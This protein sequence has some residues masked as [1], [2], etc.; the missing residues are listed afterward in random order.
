M[1][2][3]NGFNTKSNRVINLAV[4]QASALG[5]SYIGSEHL[6]LGLVSEDNGPSFGLLAQRGVTLAPVSD[7]V[8]AHAGRGMKTVLTPEDITQ[9]GRQILENALDESRMRA[10]REVTPEHIL[11]ALLKKTQSGGAMMLRELGVDA[12]AL[13]AQL[14]GF[15]DIETERSRRQQRSSARSV[16]MNLLPKYAKDLCELAAE[17]RLDPVIGRD[18]EI[19]RVIQ[20]LCRRSKN[21]PCLIGEAGVGKTAVVEGLAQRIHEGNVPD[22]IRDKRVMVLDL[23]LVVAGTKYRGDFEDRLKGIISEVMNAEHIILFIDEIHN[24]MGIGAAEGAVDAANI[25]KPQ[26]ARGE[27]QIIGA[28]TFDEYRKH[29]EKDAALSRRFQSV[30]V[31]EPCE[32]DAIAIL[33]GLRSRYE[34]HHGVLISDEAVEA[35]V[36]LSARHISDRFLPDKAVDL[37]DEAAAYIKIGATHTTS[38]APNSAEEGRFDLRRLLSATPAQPEPPRMEPCHICEVLAVSTGID[39][40]SL[41]GDAVGSLQSLESRLAKEVVGQ[42]EAVRLVSRA[43]R[44]SRVGLKDA[45][46]P[47]GSFIF[48]GPTGVGKTELCRALSRHLFG[49]TG[50]M[51]RLDMSEYMEKHAVSRLIGSPPGYVGH[52]EGGQLT[53]RIRRKP[54][55]LVVFDEIEKAHP[56]I[57]NILLQVLEE[58]QLTDAQGRAVSFKNALII[59]TSNIG[60]RFISDKKPFGFAEQQCGLD[61][62]S[63]KREVLNELKRVMRPELL[64]RV[65]EVV[66]FNR[67]G[68]DEMKRIARGMLA[69]V[70]ER[71]AERKIEARFSDALAQEIAAEGLKADSGARPLRRAIQQRIEDKI[72]DRILSGDIGEGDSLYCDFREGELAIDRIGK[73]QGQTVR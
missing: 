19:N 48:L 63:I 21:N 20:I 44:R 13:Y 37:M 23:T 64:G 52:D 57:H 68:S 18:R 50:A 46:R 72:A 67:L 12:S 30:A 22:I 4:A 65:D 70:A 66:V 39:I 42:D 43:I 62:R 33:K 38:T 29:I 40:R 71:L 25:L 36:R 35:A 45:A 41:S 51:L 9:H 8:L 59:M 28:T 34:R 69:Q 56:D 5:H 31:E 49:H 15:V 2:Y 24:I 7:R 58:G 16:K 10:D 32:A 47:V 27:L 73:R 11:M 1:F 54:Y 3:F 55:S 26:L 53:E 17:G 61:N 14:S 6:L 60:A